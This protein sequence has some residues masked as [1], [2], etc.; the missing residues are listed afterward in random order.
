MPRGRS[1][2]QYICSQFLGGLRALRVL[3]FQ[4]SSNE[5]SSSRLENW[6]LDDWKLKTLKAV[7]WYGALSL[8][9]Q[10]L[11]LSLKSPRMASSTQT[12]ADTPANRVILKSALYYVL[13]IGTG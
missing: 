8:S 6:K 1:G 9:E 3:S 2:C 5:F 7:V 4:S 10:L 13:L 11:V 12:T